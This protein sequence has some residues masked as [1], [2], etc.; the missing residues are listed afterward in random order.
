MIH[1]PGVLAGP[2]FCAPSK[3]DALHVQAVQFVRFV[4]TSAGGAGTPEWDANVSYII[5]C[6]CARGAGI[7]A[8]TQAGQRTE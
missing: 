3:T 5:D 7:R 1:L 2:A 6:F 4:A 8:R